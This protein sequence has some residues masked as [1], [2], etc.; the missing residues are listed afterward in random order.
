MTFS[1]LPNRKAQIIR[2]LRRRHR[3]NSNFSFCQIRK[4]SI[5]IAAVI[6]NHHPVVSLLRQGLSELDNHVAVIVWHGN[7]LD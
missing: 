7:F 6:M 1:K 3:L 5:G 4:E 2:H